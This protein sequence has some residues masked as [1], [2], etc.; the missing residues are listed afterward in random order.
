MPNKDGF[1]VLRTLNNEKGQKKIPVLVFS[2]LGQ[3]SD[4]AKAKSLG[5]ADYV[6]KSLF[7]FNG[8]LAKINSLV[9]K[10]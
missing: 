3:E 2:T 6:N 5:A 1:E 9:N 7:D 10:Q 4:V 8:L